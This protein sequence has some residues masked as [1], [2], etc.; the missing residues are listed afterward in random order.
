MTLFEFIVPVVALVVAG[1]GILALRREAKS[2]DDQNRH[3]P[4]E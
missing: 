1:V 4:A 3:H 2:L